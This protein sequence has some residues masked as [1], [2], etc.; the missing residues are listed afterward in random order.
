MRQL[1]GQQT[2]SFSRIRGILWISQNSRDTRLRHPHD[3][4][5]H[6]VCFLLVN[7]IRLPD[8]KLGLQDTGLQDTLHGLVAGGLLEQQGVTGERMSST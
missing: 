2:S 3:Q 1:M 4:L 6:P 8:A 7:I 5:R